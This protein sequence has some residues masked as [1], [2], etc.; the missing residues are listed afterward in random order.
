[1][2]HVALTRNDGAT[3]TPVQETATGPFSFQAIATIP[4]TLA[5]GAIVT[6]A[7]S[8]A[9]AAGNVGGGSASVKVVTSCR[10]RGCRSPSIRP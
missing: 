3:T 6:F 2:N 8:A 9:D 7:A 4:S 10:P 5:D 1:V